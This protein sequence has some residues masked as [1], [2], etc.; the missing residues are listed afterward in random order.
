VVLGARTVFSDEEA[1]P[2]G[3]MRI[4]DLDRLGTDDICNCGR[5]L[6]DAIASASY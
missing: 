1:N 3:S 2:N 6:S 4:N 5:V